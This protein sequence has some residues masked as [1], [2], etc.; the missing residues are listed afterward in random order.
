MGATAILGLLNAISTLEPAALQ[1]ISSLA[2]GLQGKT[3][4]EILAADATD[5][6]S[7]VEQAHAAQAAAAPS[8]IPGTPAPA[9]KKA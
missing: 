9:A 1:L 3:D 4:A 8:V 2:H 7:I 5:W 6:S